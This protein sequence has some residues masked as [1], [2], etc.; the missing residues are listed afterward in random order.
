MKKFICKSILIMSFMG[1]VLMPIN[2]WATDSVTCHMFQQV[3]EVALEMVSYGRPQEDI[4][5]AIR[6]KC[7]SFSGPSARDCNTMIDSYEEVIIDLAMAGFTPQQAGEAAGLCSPLAPSCPAGQYLSGGNCLVCATGTYKESTNA[8]GCNACPTSG[9]TSGTA[10]SN[11]D[12]IT[13]CYLLSGSDTTGQFE[14]TSRCNY[15]K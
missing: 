13:D 3:F 11:H 5:N 10:V 8:S 14:Y 7:D 6:G 4:R 15:S 12:S 1:V 9:T 2:S